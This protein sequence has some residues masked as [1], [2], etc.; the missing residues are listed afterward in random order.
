MTHLQAAFG[1]SEITTD[2]VARALAQ[3]VRSM[4]ARL[5]LSLA[6]RNQLV[7][8][9]RTLTDTPLLTNPKFGDPFSR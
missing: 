6:Q 2:R 4:V 3:F 1:T 8:F 7:A 5:N 9:L